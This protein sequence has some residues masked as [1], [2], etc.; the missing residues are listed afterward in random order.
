MLLDYD[1]LLLLNDESGKPTRYY[2]LLK[3][4]EKDFVAREVAQNR[5]KRFVKGIIG[6]EKASKAENSTLEGS[7]TK[8][9]AIE[10]ETIGNSDLKK[11]CEKIKSALPFGIIS[12]FKPFKDAF[13]RDFNN[14]EQKLL[15]GAAKSGCIQSSA[16][17]LAQLKTRLLYWQDKSVK[18]D[19]DKPD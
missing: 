11:V 17:K 3:D 1:F 7:N 10:N 2:Y 16:D 8:A 19:W 4:F 12:A 6:E 5:A 13:Y 15:I 14:N 18:V 9:S